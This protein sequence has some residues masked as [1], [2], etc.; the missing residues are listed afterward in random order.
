VTTEPAVA[1]QQVPAPP[2]P[3]RGTPVPE[4][5]DP[6]VET[7]LRRLLVAGRA[8][9]S[10]QPI[11]S[12]SQ[13]AAN[14]FEVHVHVPTK[15][16]PLDLRRLAR[17]VRG[18]DAAAFERLMVIS[19]LDAV[20]RRP[21]KPGPTL[22]LHV[23]ISAALLGSQSD[24]GTAVDMF[25]RNPALARSVILSLPATDTS[26]EQL[27]ALQRFAAADVGLA[28]EGWDRPAA[29]LA[30]L[31]KVNLRLLKLPADRLLDRTGSTAG[32][33]AAVLIGAAALAGV[34]IVATDVRID[35]DAVEILD[36][37]IDLMTGPRF[38]GP[39]LMQPRRDTPAK[40]PV[41]RLAG[42]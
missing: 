25:R 40:P 19:A 5:L 11:V 30:E 35:E 31:R 10:L 2:D 13:G 34:D 29:E 28:V 27:A 8:E 39:R 15:G 1:P 24:L 9:L 4:Q 33:P 6:E 26:R 16:A 42:S 14:G 17:P 20:R 12:I 21:G 37:G 32:E 38:S 3:R 23:A 18:L 41:P 36:L 7:A 22:P